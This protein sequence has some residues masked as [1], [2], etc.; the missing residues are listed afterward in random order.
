[1]QIFKQ[2]KK[3]FFEFLSRLKQSYELIAPVKTDLVRFEKIS[4]IKDI[5]LEENSYFPVKEHFFKKEE[6]L[7]QFDR[8]KFTVPK[9]KVSERVF[10]GIRRC[11]LNAIMRQDKVFI[12]DAKDPYYSAAREKSFLLGY[13]C[14]S[15]CSPYC[16]CGS[17]ALI[18]FFDLMFYDKGKYM[19]V[20]V[21]SEKGDFLVKKFS[22]FFSKTDVKI[23]DKGKKIHGTDRLEKKG[24]SGLYGNPNWK[25]GVDICLSCGACTALCP[26]CY[27]FEIYDTVKTDNI[28]KGE[29][30][31]K[32]SS[33][34]LQEFTKVAGGHVFRASREECFKHRIYHQLQ[35]FKEKYGMQMCVGC[36]RCIEG[37]P[38]RIDFV[39]IIN[40][41][42]NEGTK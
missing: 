26:T 35:Y 42:E 27:C 40:E 36:G 37:C 6:T 30:K 18:D 24:I 8:K 33:C 3:G 4:D 15:A 22:K 2:G 5:H 17:M 31:R 11:D 29:R 7:F 25:K 39:K 9:L 34:Q 32:W 14:K 38:T 28:N 16:F 1:M 21:G 13:H 12:E 20:E 19:L 10:F 41:M 23:N